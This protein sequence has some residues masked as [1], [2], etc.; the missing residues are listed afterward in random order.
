MTTT[1]IEDLILNSS[2]LTDDERKRIEQY[3]FE[4]ERKSFEKSPLDEIL[5]ERLGVIEKLLDTKNLTKNLIE[6]GIENKTE[7]AWYIT[8]SE[9][10]PNLQHY[11]LET[12]LRNQILNVLIEEIDKENKL[13]YKDFNKNHFS[14]LV[15][16]LYSFFTKNYKNRNKKTNLNPNIEWLKKHRSKYAGNYVALK[17]GKLVAFGKTIKEAETRANVK[18]VKNPLLHYIPAENEEVWGGW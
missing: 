13:T 16:W 9:K 14:T 15:D 18:E 12:L 7:I 4:T 11:F 10:Y 6:F 8:M 2:N 17:D 5:Q 1:S 3:L